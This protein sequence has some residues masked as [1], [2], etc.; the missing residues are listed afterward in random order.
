V[1]LVTIMYR[2]RGKKLEVRFEGIKTR[3]ESKLFESRNLLFYTRERVKR[4]EKGNPPTPTTL[5]LYT[6]RL[7]PS[8]HCSCSDVPSESHPMIL[9][10][11]PSFL[12]ITT[13]PHQPTSQHLRPLPYRTKLYHHHLAASSTSTSVS[14]FL[15]HNSFRTTRNILLLFPSIFVLPSAVTVSPP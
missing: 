8:N 14:A 6:I 1:I 15:S 5:S 7:P 3:Q 9:H 4:E 12:I 2:R 10:T 11:T 13:T